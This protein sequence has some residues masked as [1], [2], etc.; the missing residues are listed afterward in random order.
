M[1]D[2][3]GTTPLHSACAAGSVD[4]VRFLIVDHHCDPT[5]LHGDTLL[6]WAC[7]AESIY[8]LS[9]FSLTITV[10]QYVVA[11]WATLHCMHLTCASGKVDFVKF[12]VEECHCDPRVRNMF[13]ETP[14]YT[15]LVREGV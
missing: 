2:R 10:I 12:F 9:G 11:T 4:I 6:N 1:Q 15:W 8:T 3:G 13:G 5:T 14:L 7:S